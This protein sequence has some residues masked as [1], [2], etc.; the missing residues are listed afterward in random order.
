M[1]AVSARVADFILAHPQ[2]VMTLSLAELATAVTA[3]EGL[4]IRLCQQVGIS[5]L[6]QLKNSIGQDLA[7]PVPYIKENLWVG[8]SLSTAV[9]KRFSANIQALKAALAALKMDALQQA[10]DILRWRRRSSC[11]ASAVARRW[12]RTRTIGS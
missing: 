11:T 12:F 7:Q 10:V 9:E 5:G 2:K 6:Q 4:I 8:D 3:S 1:G